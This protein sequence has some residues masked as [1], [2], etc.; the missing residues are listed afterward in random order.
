RLHVLV[1]AEDSERRNGRVRIAKDVDSRAERHRARE[2]DGEG[3]E[4]RKGVGSD[5][6]IREALQQEH[7]LRRRIVVEAIGSANDGLALSEQIVGEAGARREVVAVAIVERVD[8]VADLDQ[9]T[10]RNEV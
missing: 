5:V 8:S 10:T 2:V 9:A 6:T 1:D 4:T 7:V 3:S